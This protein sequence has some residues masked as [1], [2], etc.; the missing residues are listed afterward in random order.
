MCENVLFSSSSFQAIIPE[1]IHKSIN[2]TGKNN[3]NTK[4]RKTIGIFQ[5]LWSIFIQHFDLASDII[6][7]VYYYK[8]GETLYFSLT[9]LFALLPIVVF[10]ALSLCFGVFLAMFGGTYECYPF[11]ILNLLTLFRLHEILM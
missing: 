10:Q 7:L 5:C 11:V 3:Y 1:P 2:D 6:L 4:T 8:N 9:L